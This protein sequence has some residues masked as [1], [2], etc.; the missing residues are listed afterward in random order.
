PQLSFKK[1]LLG[2]LDE[3]YEFQSKEFLPQLEEAIVT[4]IKAVGDVFLETHH[5][6]LSLYSRY[7]QMLPAIA[8]LRREIGEENPWMELCRKKLNHRLS[9][10]AYTM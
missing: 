4:S 10:D 2:N 9:L 8:S 1:I 3:I 5:R 7:C 6:F